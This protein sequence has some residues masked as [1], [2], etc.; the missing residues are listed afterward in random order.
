MIDFV[1]AVNELR[2]QVL[3]DVDASDFRWP[4]ALV[5]RAA[6]AVIREMMQK[7]PILL[8]D[9]ENHYLSVDDFVLGDS[10]FDEH[11]KVNVPGRYREAFIH[12]MAAQLLNGNA[13][14]Q[15]DAQR[16]AYEKSRFDELMLR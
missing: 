9:E 5:L 12:G 4:N 1:D 11:A 14:N 6:N 10:A 16:M 8:F 2:T 7:K 15:V 3:L 13:T